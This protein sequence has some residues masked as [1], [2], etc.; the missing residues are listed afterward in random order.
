MKKLYFIIFVFTTFSLNAQ[1][2]ITPLAGKP[3]DDFPWFQ[4]INNFQTDDTVY[5]G[6]DPNRFP[7]L[8]NETISVFIVESRTPDSFIT[9]FHV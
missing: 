5:L 3:L 4:Y 6:I 1:I 2:T 9:D 7:N 8:I